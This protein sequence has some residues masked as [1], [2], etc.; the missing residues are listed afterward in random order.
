MLDYLSPFSNGEKIM[1]SVAQCL[2]FSFGQAKLLLRQ[3]K[4]NES[5]SILQQTRL[6][7]VSRS[8]ILPIRRWRLG[9]STWRWCTIIGSLRTRSRSIHSL[10]RW[11]APSTSPSRS[12]SLSSSRSRCI[13]RCWCRSG[14]GPRSWGVHRSR[15]RGRHMCTWSGSIVC[16]AAPSVVWLL[17]LP[18]VIGLVLLWLVSGSLRTP[19]IV[20]TIAR[21]L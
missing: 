19:G 3:N 8:I 17:I 13:V 1:Q 20:P 12:R 2:P 15:G 21:C 9:I 10:R 11:G 16:I 14:I 18:A 5:R 4:K 6:I 7:S